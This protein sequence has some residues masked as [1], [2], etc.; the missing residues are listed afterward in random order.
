MSDLLRNII[1]NNRAGA[2]VAVPSVCSAHPDVLMASLLLAEELDRPVVIE[3]TSNQVN[4]FGGYTGMTPAEFAAFVWRLAD[5]AGVDR[6]RIVLGGD[7]LGPQVWRKGPAATAMSNAATLVADYVRAG[8]TKIHLDCSEGCAGEAAQVDDKT[9]AQRSALLARACQDA[10][11]DPAALS[12]VIGTEVPPPGGARETEGGTIAP[13]SPAAA[14]A[15]LAAHQHAFAQAGLSDLWHQVCGL[16]V[17]PGVEFSPD[18]VFHL[19]PCDGHDLRAVLADWPGLCFEAHS[20]DYQHPDAYPR[21]A[22]MGFALQ[23]VGPALTF[24]WR[25]AVY[26]LDM[27]AQVI[28]LGLEPLPEVMERAML[29]RPGY[30]QGHYHGTDSH[31]LRLLRH[32]SYADRIRYYWPE[33][34]AQAAVRQLFAALRGQT[35]PAA[36]LAQCFA[37]EVVERAHS[38][39]RHFAG[40]QAQ[41]LVAAQVQTALLPY[42]FAPHH[43]G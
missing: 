7:H 6:G 8:F 27:I 36:A 13:T 34:E 3:A 16:V 40:D 5:T 35:L 37:P 30:W 28:G 4:Q 14:S 9:A 43:A 1:A 21:L 31:H 22:A 29:A 24:A 39:T 33:A 25:Q 41:A 17:Q 42:F 20:T 18:T 23:K 38:L 2:A 19:P 10:A 11:P 32:F 15:T 26:G 12:L